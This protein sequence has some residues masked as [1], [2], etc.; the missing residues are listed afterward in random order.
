M[1]DSFLPQIIVSR[2]L[3]SNIISYGH[4]C[5]LH[6]LQL[7][8]RTQLKSF[9]YCIWYLILQV[10]LQSVNLTAKNA[11]RKLLLLDIQEKDSG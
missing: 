6:E 11:L 5:E 1:P 10:I 7:L 8:Q 9:Q 4:D 3:E 2:R